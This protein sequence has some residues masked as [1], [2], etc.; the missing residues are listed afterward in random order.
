MLIWFV[1]GAIVSSIIVFI[2]YVN[3]KKSAE[4]QF[5]SMSEWN[6]KLANNEDM[7]QGV[8]HGDRYSLKWVPVEKDKGSIFQWFYKGIILGHM[9]EDVE[10]VYYCE[11]CEKIVID[12][13]GKRDSRKE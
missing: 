1:V 4:K 8:I 11:K 7:H 6:Q 10:P 5:R 12:T 13:K 3:S 2:H 9:G